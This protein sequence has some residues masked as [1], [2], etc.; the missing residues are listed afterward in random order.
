MGN[1]EMH[2]SEMRDMFFSIAWRDKNYV[3]TWFN[4]LVDQPYL[5]PDLQEFHQLVEKGRKLIASGEEK[6]LRDLVSEM[7]DARIALGASDMAGELATIVKT[8]SAQ[9]AA[10]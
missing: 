4:R 7:L 10:A 6:P 2:L 1:A 5:Y 9:Q 8:T 3:L